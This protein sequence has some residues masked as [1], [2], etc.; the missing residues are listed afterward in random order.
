MQHVKTSWLRRLNYGL[1]GVTALL[2]AVYYIFEQ[3]GVAEATKAQWGITPLVLTLGALHAVFVLIADRTFIKKMPWLTMIIS[4]TLFSFMNSALIE[5]SGGTNAAYR[6]SSAVVIFLSAMAGVFAPVAAIVFTWMVLVFTVTGI[7]TPS[8]TSLTF[9]IIANTATTIAGYLGWWFFSKFYLLSDDRETQKL[10]GVLEQEQLKSNIILESITDGVLIIS[11]E[12]TVQ[13]LNES[14]A[15][16]LGWDRKEATNL[17]FRSLYSVEVENESKREEQ[18]EDAITISLKSKKAVKKISLLKTKHQKNTYID[19]VASPIYQ[20]AVA[21]DESEP[22]EHMVGVVA[23]LRDVDAQ[24]RQGQQRSDFISTASHEMRT[25]VA[26]IQG[27]LELALNKKVA[28]VDDKAR[29]Y[30]EKAYES[31]KHLGGLFQDLLTASKSEDGRLVNKPQLVD[32]NEFL[33]TA[34]E[35]GKVNAQAKNL[36]VQLADA[37]PANGNS[38]RPLLYVNAD[39]ERLHEVVMNLIENA[40][41]YTKKGV[42]TVGAGTKDESVI[43]RISDTGIGIAAEDIPHLFQKFYRTDNSETR[44]VG[45]TG[46][47]LYITK[48]IVEMMGGKVWVESEIGAGSTFLVQIPR[49]APGQVEQMRATQELQQTQT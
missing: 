38:V 7:T 16:M 29:G 30:L 13:V 33:E 31:T 37:D 27:F 46:L 32:V 26:A 40:I 5:S 20:S 14:S 41:K 11:P 3:L 9:N 35:Q 4:I 24:T 42:I 6:I 34:V 19:I 48:Q 17:D 44:E 18:I 28:Q 43:I 49:V 39:P 45:G 15:R 12:G 22:K 21:T 25:P 36:D 10:A 2:F 23:V 8:N 47:G 1:V